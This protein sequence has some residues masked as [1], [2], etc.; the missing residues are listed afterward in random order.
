MRVMGRMIY[1]YESMWIDV[2][3]VVVMSSRIVYYIVR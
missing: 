3:V 1:S 2:S